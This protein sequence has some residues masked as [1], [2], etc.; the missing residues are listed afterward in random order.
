M[1]IITVR[2]FVPED[3]KGWDAFVKNHPKSTFFH[4]AGW[5]D[6]VETSFNHKPHYFIAEEKEK[7]KGVFPLFHVKS[8]LFGNFLVSVPFVVY[9]GI[10]ADNSEVYNLLLE[11]GKKLARQLGVDYLELRN[12][13]QNE[14]N[15]PIKDLYVTFRREIFE[16]IDENMS[17]IPRKQRRM[18]RVG[19]NNG[20]QSKIGK[21]H[22]KEFYDIYAHSLRNLG[23]PV[24]PYSLFKNI[25][26]V[27]DDACKILSVWHQGRMVAA[28]M[29]FFF[30]DIVMPYYGGA[31]RDSFRYAVND[32][33][34]WELMKYG[35]ENGYKTFD[36][37]RSKRGTGSY[38]FKRHWGF[39]PEPLPYQYYMVKQKE[40]PNLSPLNPKF[41]P[42]ISLWKRMPLPITKAIGPRII[43]YIP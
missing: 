28:V 41:K 15:L 35:C 5:K 12:L 10:C 39:E 37:G 31:L 16:D 27:F 9:G 34:Y 43:K 33:M 13:E 40:T 36:F 6:I 8:L 19:I 30:K 21:E 11:E 20:C 17:V 42:L 2:Y 32:F 26:R 1:S 25:M 38:D 29:T 18:I 24:F 23:T 14:Y 3:R 7:I 4:L 22:L